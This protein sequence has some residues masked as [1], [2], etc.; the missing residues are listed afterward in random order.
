MIVSTIA[1]I[2]KLADGCR[3]GMSNSRAGQMR[4]KPQMYLDSLGIFSGR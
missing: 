1:S 2:L 3:G 4:A